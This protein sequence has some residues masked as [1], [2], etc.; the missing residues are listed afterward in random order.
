LG[1]KLKRLSLIIILD[2]FEEIQEKK[3]IIKSV[4]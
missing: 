2:K 3:K 1:T 4:N